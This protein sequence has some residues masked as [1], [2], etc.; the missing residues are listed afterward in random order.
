M[1]SRRSPVSPWIPYTV[2]ITA[3]LLVISVAY[4][5]VNGHP[6]SSD[7]SLLPCVQLNVTSSTEKS[8]LIG[9]LAETYGK[10]N[11]RI[12][13]GRCVTVSVDPFTSGA[14][15]KA[16]AS[17]WS[18]DDARGHTRK[19]HVWLPSSSLW[20]VELRADT[21]Y[22]DR[23]ELPGTSRSIA[24]SPMVIAMPEEMARAIGWPEK[25]LRWK[26][27]LGL[28]RNTWVRSGY[29]DWG[30]FSYVKDDPSFSTSGFA[31]TIATYYSAA[32]KTQGLTTQD[33][34]ANKKVDD[35]VRKV[36][37]NVSYYPPDIMNFL[38]EMGGPGE[39][40]KFSAVVMQ[41]M[42]AYLHNQGNPDG[43]PRPAGSKPSDPQLVAIHPADGTLMLDHP[44]V[45]LPG[46]EEDEREAAEAF[47]EFLLEPT[48]RAE[49]TALGFRYGDGLPTPN[50]ASSLGFSEGQKST[51]MA[52]PGPEVIT[53]I[54]ERWQELSKRASLLILVDRS[55][56]MAEDSTT[57]GKD[58]M[59]AAKEALTNNA[60]FLN[61]KDQVE[62]WGFASDP[63]AL[64]PDVLAKSE[65]GDGVAFGGA[66]GKLATATGQY[67]DTALCVTVR[68]AH[69]H[70]LENLDRS[71]I[72]A[73]V[74]LTDG[75]ND[76]HDDPCSMRTLGA[77]LAEDDPNGDVKMF[78]IGIGSEKEGANIPAL[79]GMTRRTGITFDAVKDPEKLDT[80]FADI[81][82]TVSPGQGL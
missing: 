42:L 65:F 29:G 34:D 33:I 26:D 62:I 10:S 8:A 1:D 82:R 3:S 23:D 67:D 21:S 57:P 71:R 45:I 55:G 75:K 49:F 68:D 25:Q 66:V 9:S 51:L 50:L 61:T 81:F 24:K 47:M 78:G 35:F 59:E 22:A 7:P 44:Y 80:A 14:A 17:N 4:W 32:G 15:K 37:A 12:G 63:N 36:E 60:T 74:I 19:P 2:A 46:V 69:K 48:R 30:P 56:S 43:R 39:K 40:R 27:V 58:R 16:I 73:I 13:S 72:N 52:V 11:P 77:K 70:M 79:R 38:G 64:H 20:I 54:R 18:P 41:E 31:A 6:S 53:R 5:Y 76:Y 28:D